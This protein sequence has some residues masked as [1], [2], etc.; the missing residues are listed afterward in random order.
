MIKESLYYGKILLFGEYGIIQDSM[1]YLSLIL[2]IMVNFYTAKPLHIQ[3]NLTTLLNYYN[4]LVSLKKDGNLP[5]DLNLDKFKEELDHGLYFDSS[6]P[7]GFGIGSS[8]AIV[9]AIYDKFC[10]SDKIDADNQ[11]SN[12]DILALK[13]YSVALS[14]FHGQVPV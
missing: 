8:G 6:I 5:C 1:A 7:Q 9:A 10:K 12:E 13:K 11:I 4:H 2:I 14:Y 3:Q